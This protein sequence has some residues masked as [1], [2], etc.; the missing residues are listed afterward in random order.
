[1]RNDI[2][3]RS[4]SDPNFMEGQMEMEDS[5]ELFKQQI[6]SILFTPKTTVMGSIDF[7]AS[8][9]E[10]VWSFRTSASALKA[11]ISWP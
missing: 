7:G 11:A 9:E 3:N 8:L 10:Y 4:L 5:I 1:M 2:Y 6:E